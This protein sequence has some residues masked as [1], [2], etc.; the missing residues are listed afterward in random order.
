MRLS[1]L[2]EAF[3]DGA[4]V[5]Y[6]SPSSKSLPLP[7]ILPP[8]ACL[9]RDCASSA[10]RPA[11][12]HCLCG[13]CCR[14]THRAIASTSA[15]TNLLLNHLIKARC[16]SRPP[17]PCACM[18]IPLP[19]PLPAVASLLPMLFER[20]AHVLTF[21]CR[22]CARRS[23]AGSERLPC[24]TCSV[25]RRSCRLRPRCPISTVDSCCLRQPQHVRV[26]D[27]VPSLVTLSSRSCGRAC[28]SRCQRSRA[29][30]AGTENSS[31]SRSRSSCRPVLSVV[32]LSSRPVVAAAALVP[33]LSCMPCGRQLSH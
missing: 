16:A 18:C 17:S 23:H 32:T 6:V 4:T 31:L 20:C 1:A 33:A 14:S 21:A 29:W 26:L 8:S 27:R 5:S 30:R 3:I 11:S 19:R 25:K 15:H 24:V 28:G 13:L 7:D 2:P 12:C 10:P 22:V 9:Q